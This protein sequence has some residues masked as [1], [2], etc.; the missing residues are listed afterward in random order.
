MPLF[1][2]VTPTLLRPTLRRT[3]ESIDSQTFTDYEHVV[4]YD[5]DLSSVNYEQQMIVNDIRKN[6]K[7]KVLCTGKRIRDFGNTPRN[8]GCKESSGDLIMYL[9]DDDYHVNDTMQRLHDWMHLGDVSRVPDLGV[10]M[11][12]RFQNLFLMWPPGICRTTSCQWFHKRAINGETI[13]WPTH[14]NSYV[15]DGMFLE[16]VI[17]KTT[18]VR[19]D[20]DVPL[21]IV[22]VASVGQ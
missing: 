10:F 19:I 11:C 8:L 22:D 4:V 20:T 9:D 14:E 13:H 2:I 6:E 5:G 7:R 15:S 16:S 3:C 18:P 21:V 1:T 17:A 12:R